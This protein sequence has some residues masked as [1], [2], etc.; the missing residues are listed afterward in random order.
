MN[1]HDDKHRTG[2]FM[3]R[4][5]LSGRLLEKLEDR[6]ET[7]EKT[8]F[9][10]E[11]PLPGDDEFVG[12]LERTVL[13][14]EFCASSILR[15]PGMLVE[16]VNSGDLYRS[17]E[18]DEYFTGLDNHLKGIS[19]VDGL[20]AAVSRVRLREMV[21]IAWR[22]LN[23]KASLDETI[24]ELSAL[25]D[26]CVETVISFIYGKMCASF[27]TPRDGRGKSQGLVVLGMG[28]LGAGE[29]NFSSDIDLIFAY[30]E[31]TDMPGQGR[32]STTGEFFTKLCRQFLK[33]F[34]VSMGESLIFRVDTRLR[35]FGDNGPMVMSFD[36]MEIYYQTQGRDWERY[37]FIKARPVAG[38]IEAGYVLLK[39][40]N[41]FVYR[42]YF[43]YGA[44]ESFRDMKKRIELQVRNRRL[45][46]NIKLGAGGIRE[47]EFFG[48]IFQ[49][50]RGGVE[51]E[52][53]ERKILSV[54]T[55]LVREGF[56][57]SKTGDELKRA[58]V[59]LRQVEHRLQIYNDQQTHEIP[60]RDDDRLRLAISMGFQSI[61]DFLGT[62]TLYM[63]IVHSHFDR[64]LVSDKDDSP[65]EAL[66]NL[67]FVW[68]HLS[69]PQ[70]EDT[71]ESI[72]GFKNPH[73]VITI[74]KT[75]SEHPNTSRLTASGRKRLNRLVPL[76]IKEASCQDAP[77]KV[78][79]RLQEFIIA[80]ETRACYLSL[81][82]ENPGTIQ[83][84]CVLAS[85]G[86]W[87]ISFLSRHPALLDELL[88]TA[89][90]YSPPDKSQMV[91][92]IKKRLS[93]LPDDDV[94]YQLEDLCLFKQINTLRVAV[95]DISGSYPLMKVSDRLTFTAETILEKVLDIAWVK[96]TR[97][98]GFPSGNSG[99]GGTFSGFAVVAYGKMGGLELGYKS[100]LDLVFIHSGASGMTSGGVKCIENARF[101]ILLAQRIIH[102]LTIHT[103]A[104]K[105][106]DVDMRLRPSGQSGMIVSHIDAFSEYIFSQAWTWEHQAII[107][108]RPVCG[109]ENL[110]RR[111]NAVRREILMEER[112]PELLREEVRDMRERLRRERVESDNAGFDLK[113][114]RGGIVDIEFLVQYLVLR[115]ASEHPE[116]TLWTDNVRLL[117]TLVL[118]KILLQKDA[119]ILKDAYLNFR[120]AIHHLNL[121]EKGEN[122][123]LEHFSETAAQVL[124]IYG[125][126][127]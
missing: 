101:Y 82:L 126:F 36:A 66:D 61:D 113:Q 53:Q 31:D 32:V 125:K 9:S 19:D 121:G 69:D 10:G 109:D 55:L 30:S 8:I 103:Q 2:N 58:Y 24:T 28:K 13:F 57:D 118:E 25:A 23:R 122:R 15:H 54:L 93:L 85:K 48:Q 80:I 6:M 63:K 75:L 20:R 43:D 95:A 26:A 116:L 4:A 1:D 16:L 102:M 127:L 59:F 62:L 79:A 107:R 78:L 50:I 38:D 35:P 65:D 39:K 99:Y 104:G 94:E 114:G 124:A 47:I 88:D 97:K 106:Y 64:L 41:P 89:T 67:A 72:P 86:P 112:E 60:D 49:M 96:I 51:P 71:M 3:H 52:F 7:F 87:I 11:N 18:K 119:S 14:S 17:Y 105:L 91:R 12:E 5:M 117:E 108:A 123:A 120:R 92:E 111:F 115:H 81:L 46:H 98:Y 22:D 21:R 33:V 76:M 45:K 83:T 27:G 73:G 29:L 74:L 77:E 70:A 100:D 37:A 56:I 40:L 110:Q 34:N 42:R 84:L 44:F 90:L 68:L